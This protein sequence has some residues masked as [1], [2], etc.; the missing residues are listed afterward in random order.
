MAIINDDLMIRRVVVPNLYC[1]TIASDIW[2]CS[3]NLIEIQNES[4]EMRHW[5]FWLIGWDIFSFQSI[6]TWFHSNPMEN[7]VAPTFCYLQFNKTKLVKCDQKI[8]IMYLQIAIKFIIHAAKIAAHLW[9]HWSRYQL[10]DKF[11]TATDDF[12]IEPKTGH[13]VERIIEN[14]C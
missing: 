9:F 11:H 13:K 12:K 2:L 5:I 8:I 1:D 10:N 14:C 4:N 7:L 6:L 3:A